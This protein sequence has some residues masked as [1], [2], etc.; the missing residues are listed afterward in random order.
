MYELKR[1]ILIVLVSLLAI[2]AVSS[3][4]A[5]H[6]PLGQGCCADPNN[7]DFCGSTITSAQAQNTCDTYFDKFDC[8]EV[9]DCQLISGGATCADKES[10]PTSCRSIL[11]K[12][13]CGS[14]EYFISKPLNQVSQC[15]QGCC[16]CVFQNSAT[17]Q[18]SDKTTGSCQAVCS[19]AVSFIFDTSKNTQ[20]CLQYAQQISTNIGQFSGTATITGIITSGG[21]PLSGAT[22][23]GGGASATTSQ[24]GQYT[25]SNAAVG[26]YP[27][28]ASKLGYDPASISVTTTSGATITGINLVLSQS[29]VTVLRGFVKSTAS[30]NP[31]IPNATVF[32]STSPSR[33][34][35]ANDLGEYTFFNVPQGSITITAQ[36]SGFTQNTATVNVVSNQVNNAP[37]ILLQPGTQ[38]PPPSG[39]S[40][41]TVNVLEPN[42]GPL[43]GA[44]VTLQST[45]LPPGG[46]IGFTDNNGNVI[47]NPQGGLPN[48]F[49]YSATASHTTDY[50]TNTTATPGLLSGAATLTVSLNK[51]PKFSIIGRVKDVTNANVPFATVFLDGSQTTADSSGDYAFT[52]L[53]AGFPYTLRASKSGYLPSSPITITALNANEVRDLTLS[54]VSCSTPPPPAVSAVNHVVGKP[55]LLV[56]YVSS[57][58][59][60]NIYIQRCEGQAD[61]E[62]PI[63]FQASAGSVTF[64][65]EGPL[66][67]NTQYCYRTQATFSS[68]TLTLS[69]SY[70][71]K[72]TGDQICLDGAK[73]FCQGKARQYCNITN[74][75]SRR[76]TCGANQVCM[77]QSPTV[78]TCQPESPCKV[79]NRPFGLF[80][81]NGRAQ[82]SNFIL[83]PC[84]NLQ[85][86]YL[87]FTNTS[88][89]QY[90]ECSQVTSCYDYRSKRACQTENK[91]LK[92]TQCEWLPISTD[93]AGTGV[94]RPVDEEKRK[95][96]ACLNNV[97]N[98]VFGGCTKEVCTAVADGYCK[99][100]DADGLCE[101]CISHQDLG[102]SDYPQQDCGTTP[103]DVDVTWFSGI[104][105]QF[106]GAGTNNILT[107]SDDVFGVGLC[108]FDSSKGGCFKDADD[109]SEPDPGDPSDNDA[110][111]TTVVYSGIQKEFD[112]NYSAADDTS[113]SSGITTWFS[114]SN[115]GSPCYPAYQASGGK[116]APSG[117]VVSCEGQSINALTDGTYFVRYFSEDEASN[118]EPVKQFTIS[119]DRTP[120]ALVVVTKRFVEGTTS[121]TRLEAN[122]T[123]NEFT[124]CSAH[125]HKGGTS[126]SQ[127][128][129][130]D[131]DV[132]KPGYSWNDVY[133]H[134]VADVYTYHYS[135]YDGAGNTVS[136]EIALNV[137]ADLTIS[138]PE[139]SQEA[140]SSNTN[141]P[142]SVKT[143]EPAACEYAD[144]G[145]SSYIPFANTGGTTHTDVI[146]SLPAPQGQM[147]HYEYD[148]RCAITS[149]NQVV[150]GSLADRIR[151][152]I[153]F[154]PPVTRL[155]NTSDESQELT[156]PGWI[157]SNS[158]LFKV[159]CDDVDPIFTDTPAEIGCDEVYYCTGTN[160]NPNP[161]GVSTYTPAISSTTSM[162]YY[163]VDNAGNQEA[164]L[165]TVFIQVDNFPPSI[166]N[167]LPQS[168]LLTGQLALQVS[169]TV[170]DAESDVDSSYLE[171]NGAQQP[172]TPSGSN[173][174]TING[175]AILTQNI[176]N[177]IKIIALDKAGNK[178][179][180]TIL[181]TQNSDGP[182]ISNFRLETKCQGACHS[183]GIYRIAEVYFNSRTEAIALDPQGVDKVWFVDIF[184]AKTSMTTLGTNYVADPVSSTLWPVGTHAITVAA[185]DTLGN[186]NSQQY[187]VTVRDTIIPDGQIFVEDRYGRRYGQQGFTSLQ[188]GRYYLYINATEPLNSTRSNVSWSNGTETFT[189]AVL[190]TAKSF[191]SVEWIGYFDIQENPA[192]APTTSTLS[193]N[194]TDKHGLSKQISSPYA[195]DPTAPPGPV[196]IPSY[197]ADLSISGLTITPSTNKNVQ[198]VG[199]SYITN[200]HTVTISGASGGF[201]PVYV[202]GADGVQYSLG[203]SILLLGATLQ[204]KENIIT[205]V[206][207]DSS[208]QWHG[209]QIRIIKDLAPPQLIFLAVERE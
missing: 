137:D 91:C 175:L 52:N 115:G 92:S 182:S 4:D 7:D 9:P 160:C 148:V 56:N 174:Y 125:L 94:C 199:T 180:K 22:V 80:Q 144:A 84:T 88:V 127:T 76:A 163:S 64:L 41:I 171:I 124:W 11:R 172:I 157:N 192:P 134:L 138:D 74:T 3:V 20:Q 34:T 79:C 98:R 78:T 119:I 72:T 42:V 188:T 103:V 130:K 29:T 195:L 65:D 6:L 46:I 30:G 141:I 151:I 21:N 24:S 187:T 140:I 66:S 61:C 51:R 17:S 8:T 196:P 158:Y 106:K 133:E 170:G 50:W 201:N 14:S 32:L 131:V 153:D 39:G 122:I 206:G 183:S 156:L 108:R 164:P 83:T 31:I 27:V 129:S 60:D 202:Y 147:S 109:Q 82:G 139:P 205:I 135:C 204:E 186:I 87:D 190:F 150:Q 152:T 1:G 191:D 200:S 143:S 126:G 26:T 2:I 45:A 203:A 114:I 53:L 189:S 25:L 70:V 185:N 75:I 179:S 117:G 116:I 81:L 208:Q 16:V 57:C 161:T 40:A 154:R 136:D 102:C 28:T 55:Q 165:K 71:C 105:G 121:L 85:F 155:V 197:I 167:T 73:D 77:S 95:T 68:P 177:N 149:T 18:G 43:S 38:Q 181:I 123:S 49:V 159:K 33:I 67:A 86:C 90:Q 209:T 44:Q 48:G 178:A 198:Q 193:A 15:Q 23:S 69:S 96:E 166:T 145:S 97:Y 112:F 54:P 10:N 47:F 162:S 93:E 120:P 5:S 146:A 62:N 58:P 107:R 110:P 194:L 176:L 99:D 19:N 207:Q 184:G 113:D 63:S 59:A 12:A 89:D 111:N 104:G 36:K 101:D 142:I 132:T 13:E 100:H 37:D 118:L 169:G 35:K 173:P 128:N 168:G